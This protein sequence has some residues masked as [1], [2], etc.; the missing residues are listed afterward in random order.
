MENY[1]DV[2]TIPDLIGKKVGVIDPV[3]EREDAEMATEPM[4]K[5]QPIFP[6]DALP[7][8]L[9]DVVSECAQSYGTPPEVW[10][11]AFLSGISAAAGKRFKLINRNYANYPQ[12]WLMVVGASGTGKSDPFRIAFEPLKQCDDD[13]YLVYR[14]SVKEW[15]ACD[16]QGEKPRW[17]QLL[18]N[19]TTPEAL[20]A[21]LQYAENGLTL[22][23]DELSGFFDDIGR[24]NRSGE[25]GHYLSIF[26]ND[27]FSV[28]RKNDEPLLIRKPLLN[29]VGTVQPGVLEGI[30]SKN[31]AETSGFMQRFLFLFPE[32]PER[33][34]NPDPINPN[35][36]KNYHNL[37]QSILSVTDTGE[38]R[39]SS[40]AEECYAEYFRQCEKK[41]VKSDDFW[42]SVYSKAE[43][44]ALRLA[45]LVKIARLPEVPTPDVEIDDVKCAIGITD[46]CISSL[47]KFK[48]KFPTKKVSKAELIEGIFTEFPDANQ[49]EVARMFGVSQPYINKLAK[50]VRL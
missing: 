17:E 41:R 11:M 10:A 34:Y 44:Q 23:R 29:I 37:V 14:E 15:E 36:L 39:L 27:T 48:G 13:A 43:I 21:A 49:S 20:Y 33:G 5:E 22:Y 40:D 2:G 45:L 31:N 8:W 47:R 19:D 46:F 42:A 9:Q 50:R 24:Y 32:F 3:K 12:I 30:F 1:F 28:N 35:I 26:S 16:K 7:E 6:F 18:I 4:E 38:T 25:I